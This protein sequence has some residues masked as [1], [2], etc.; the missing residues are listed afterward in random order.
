[1][2]SLLRIQPHLRAPSSIA[3]L[4]RTAFNLPSQRYYAQKSS[5]KSEESH[6]ERQDKNDASTRH[7]NHPIPSN[8]AEPTLRDGKQSPIADHE[9]N[10]RDD[11]P[12]DVKK[13]NEDVE[14]RYDK[15]YNHI[16]DGGKTEPV[17]KK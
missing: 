14:N 7:P 9:G 11:L 5:E 13:H 12:E 15:P 16:G 4:G 1:M 8:K 3:Y 2:T 6:A 10:L 17:W